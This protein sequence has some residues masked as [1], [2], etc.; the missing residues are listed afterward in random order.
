MQKIESIRF[1]LTVAF[2]TC[3][4]LF[5][6]TAK[7]T[8]KDLNDLIKNT[9]TLVKKIEFSAQNNLEISLSKETKFKAFILSNPHRLVIDIDNANFEK[10]NYKPAASKLIKSF[11]S[12]INE[13]KS[14]RIVFDLT[15]K[16]TIKKSEFQ[17]SSGKIV[18]EFS[19]KID[20]SYTNPTNLIK[21]SK[22]VKPKTKVIVIDAGH[23]GKDPGTIG[24]YART[25][26]KNITLSYAK[27]L[28][29]YLD[30]TKKYKV[31]LTRDKDYFI[32]L[33]GRVEKA[34]KL[35]ADLFISLHANSIGDHVTSGLSIYT[36]SENSSDKQ[37]ELLAR[38][39]N[40]ADIISGVNFSGASKD[41]M[42]TLIGLSQRDSM[43]NSSIFA[44]IAIASVRNSDIHV[45]QNTHRF[46]GFAVLTAPDMA[47][48]LI[49]LGYL[50]NK[51][52]EKKLNSLLHK[53][54]ITKSLVEA[55]NK[56][57]TKI[58]N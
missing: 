1:W 25:R 30:N 22:Y 26:E 48:V 34:R 13:E 35:K 2:M 57:F 3:F 53:R 4:M 32:P 27:E 10:K 47:S 39:E 24:D 29:K 19:E 33:K 42:S 51:Y 28:K 54:K 52:E 11:R 38:K 9:S 18:T 45:L 43:N 7:D 12:S 31:Y 6:A 46:A 36:L 41:I 55:I 21:Y 14:L 58:K 20:S 50:S 17:K 49:E 23:G 16:L 8:P 44:N 40:R 37:A 15:K 56:Y 5:D